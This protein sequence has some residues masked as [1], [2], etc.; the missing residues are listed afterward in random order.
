MGVIRSLLTSTQ[1]TLQENPPF[2]GTQKGF[3]VARHEMTG[4]ESD[5]LIEDFKEHHSESTLGLMGSQRGTWFSGPTS[6]IY[7]DA[8]W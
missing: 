3:L 8:R 7:K 6:D 5:C 4:E 1:M 2:F